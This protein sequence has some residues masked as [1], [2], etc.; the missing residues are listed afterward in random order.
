M[1]QMPPQTAFAVVSTTRRGAEI[2]MRQTIASTRTDARRKFRA[3]W[4]DAVI[5]P[6]LSR[7]MATRGYRLAAITLTVTPQPQSDKRI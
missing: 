5:G 7:F 3:L 2:V 4:V 6:S 1:R